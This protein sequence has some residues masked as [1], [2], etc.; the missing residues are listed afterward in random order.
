MRPWRGAAL[1]D[2]MPGEEAVLEIRPVFE[3]QQA[4]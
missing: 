4:G 3:S 1:P 2:P